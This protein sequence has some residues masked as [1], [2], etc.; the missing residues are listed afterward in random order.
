MSV[1][2]SVSQE[3]K[4]R[5]VLYKNG[6]QAVFK[7]LDDESEQIISVRKVPINGRK[8]TFK[9]SHRSLLSFGDGR[10]ECQGTTSVEGTRVGGILIRAIQDGWYLK[11]WV[12]KNKDLL[13]APESGDLS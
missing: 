12:G 6:S 4:T 7:I 10:L 13:P 8:L 9:V 3:N 1:D 2:Q 5:T 11:Y